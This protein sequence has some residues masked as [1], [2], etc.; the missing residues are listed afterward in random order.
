[1]DVMRVDIS[2][3]G[4]AGARFDGSEV[5]GRVDAPTRRRLEP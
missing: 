2:V 4:I 5:L 3:E 1:M